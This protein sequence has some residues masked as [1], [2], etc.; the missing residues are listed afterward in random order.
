MFSAV[1]PDPDVSAW[2][3][4]LVFSLTGCGIPPTCIGSCEV[5]ALVSGTFGKAGE[6]LKLVKVHLAVAGDGF[7]DP[8]G[9]GSSLDHAS[10]RAL[11][12]ASEAFRICRNAGAMR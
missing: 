7:D 8:H 6:A 11:R 2:C 1:F 4:V 10:K 12:S 5:N 3:D 9:I